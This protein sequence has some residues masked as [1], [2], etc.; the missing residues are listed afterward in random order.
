MFEKSRF[1]MVEFHL[2]LY[3]VNVLF[4][5]LKILSI[6]V[7][8]FFGS[9]LVRKARYT[10]RQKRIQA[11]IALGCFS[12][13]AFVFLRLKFLHKTRRYFYFFFHFIFLYRFYEKIPQLLPIFLFLYNII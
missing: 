6:S 4:F 1:K 9:S 5:R 8:E 12:H 13:S 7:E 2:K 10:A 3:D 11:N